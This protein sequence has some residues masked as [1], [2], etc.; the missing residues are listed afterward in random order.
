[1]AVYA[2]DPDEDTEALE[3]RVHVQEMMALPVETRYRLFFERHAL[4]MARLR[5]SEAERDRPPQIVAR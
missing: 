3:R 2:F 5:Q 4:N 1:M